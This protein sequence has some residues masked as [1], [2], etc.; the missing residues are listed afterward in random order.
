MVQ[1]S[2][3]W[4]TLDNTPRTVFPILTGA[5]A[6]D[7]GAA[8]LREDRRGVNRAGAWDLFDPLRLFGVGLAIGSSGLVRVGLLSETVGVG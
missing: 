2:L 3:A 1:P 8:N 4:V 6:I 5:S 7:E